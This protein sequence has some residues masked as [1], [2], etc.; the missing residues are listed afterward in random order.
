MT[1]P[2]ASS[3]RAPAKV[4]LFLRVLGRRSD[5]FHE[6]D[7]L[8]QAVGLW[9]EVSVRKTR[10]DISLTLDGPD[11]GPAAENLAVRAARRFLDEVGATEGAD[12]HLRKGIPAGAG[13][14]GGSSDAAAVLRAM[15]HLWGRPLPGDRLREMGATLGSDVPFF[16]GESPLARG[17]GRGEKLRFLAPLPRAA[18]VLVLP[19]V[20]VATAAAYQALAARRAET[21]HQVGAAVGASVGAP[22]PEDWAQVASS[23]RNDFEAVVPETYPEVRRSLDAL[24]GAGASVALLSGSGG[25]CFG[26]FPELQ[27]AEVAARRLESEL[28]WPARAVPTLSSLPEPVP[29]AGVGVEGPG[30]LG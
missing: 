7:T 17:T 24:A 11:L 10:R 1:D 21:G 14:G 4:N 22:D 12:I 15:N 9:D 29:G 20:H 19:P 2:G 30:P 16:L 18:L 27:A 13:L 8:F 26:L 3:I 6:L 23:A 25:A 5:G 28:G